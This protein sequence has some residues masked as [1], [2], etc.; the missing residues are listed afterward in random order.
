M[1]S[2]HA[3]Q[4]IQVRQRRPRLDEPKRFTTDTVYAVID[5][6][7]RQAK[8]DQRAAWIRGHWSIENKIR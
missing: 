1:T 6:R 8:P 3:A 2:P 5:L 7:T 4:A